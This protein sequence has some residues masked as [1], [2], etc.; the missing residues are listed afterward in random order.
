MQLMLVLPLVTLMFMMIVLPAMGFTHIW[1]LR[2]RPP[3]RIVVLGDSL[4]FGNGAHLNMTGPEGFPEL[5]GRGNYTNRLNELLQ[6]FQVFNASLPNATVIEIP[7]SA[8][9]ASQYS[10]TPE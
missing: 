4:A 8:E 6:Q 9:T 1:K 10:F 7:E 5:H 2:L 3:P